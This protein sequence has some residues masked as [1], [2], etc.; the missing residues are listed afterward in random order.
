MASKLIIENRTDLIEQDVFELVWEVIKK[1]RISNN[2]KQYCYGTYIKLY[3]REFMIY[4][5]LNEKSDRF[6]ISEL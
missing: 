1:G 4:T 3:N 2:R 5:D 6:V